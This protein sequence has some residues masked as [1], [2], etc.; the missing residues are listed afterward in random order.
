MREE[1]YTIVVDKE[2][3]GVRAAFLKNNDVLSFYFRPFSRQVGAG[4]ICLGKVTG[5]RL[6]QVGWFMDL[7]HGRS[8][9]LPANK[10]V[11][12]RQPEP[13]EFRIVQIEKEES[14]GKTAGLTEQIQIIG[15]GIIYLPFGRYIAVSHKIS[16]HRD[17]FRE[18]ASEWCVSPEGAIVR[19]MGARMDVG[20]LHNEF[21]KL[22][23]RWRKISEDGGRM[24]RPGLIR[25]QLSF[26][27]WILNENHF[28]ASCTVY[29]NL[30]L[31]DT[32]LPD[33]VSVNYQPDGNNLFARHNLNGVFEASLRP[34]VPLHGG[35]SLIIDYTEALTA[36][37]VNSGSAPFRQGWKAT[38][39]D[40]NRSAAREIARQLRLREIGGMIVVD[41]L[42]LNDSSSREKVLEYLKA[43]VRD[44]PATVKIFGYTKL[45][46]VE[47]T[48]K[49]R[50]YGLMDRVIERQRQEEYR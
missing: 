50:R 20:R 22:K 28:P 27:A 12:R 41:F 24:N 35:A 47:L 4:D 38:A 37:D 3:K 29:T 1:S 23:A 34:L 44:D 39:L 6:R 25:R 9:F 15:K 33:H 21:Q 13:G 14:A 18:R 5:D 49:R 45:G 42:H 11:S 17:L 8:G 10:I 32:G 36:I 40:I 46:L 16:E 2:E 30:L 48:R 43:A 19:T 7:G 31:D 26:I